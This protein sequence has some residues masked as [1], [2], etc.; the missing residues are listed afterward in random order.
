M[1]VVCAGGAAALSRASI[2]ALTEHCLPAWSA[3]PHAA[4]VPAFPPCPRLTP[5]PRL[6]ALPRSV[7]P[8][9]GACG[10]VPLPGHRLAHRP[11]HP[12]GGHRRPHRPALPGV[13]AQGDM[14]PHHPER[15]QRR[16]A[17]RQRVCAQPAGDC[18]WVGGWVAML[19]VV[20]GWLAGWLA[21]CGSSFVGWGG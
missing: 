6:P 5:S 16:P 3:L 15:A 17:G 20:A 7:E 1:V 18:R 14:G 9:A 4:S 11:A 21:G 12:G 10:A 2:D 13:D 8:A 19:R